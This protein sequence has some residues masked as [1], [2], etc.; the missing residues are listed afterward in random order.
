MDELES[1]LLYCI[2]LAFGFVGA[3][4]VIAVVGFVMDV[5]IVHDL[6]REQVFLLSLIVGAM[7]HNIMPDS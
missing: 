3:M 6:S 7:T 4:A 5:S 2:R 1:L